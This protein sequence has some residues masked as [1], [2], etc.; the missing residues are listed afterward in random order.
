MWPL[1]SRAAAGSG[2]AALLGAA[3]AGC[4]GGA[5]PVPAARRYLTP[6]ELAGALYQAGVCREVARPA[7][8]GAGQWSCP[9]STGSLS[10]SVADASAAVDYQ[11][12][13]GCAVSGPDWLVFA[14]TGDLADDV[15]HAVGGTATCA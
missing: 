7:P 8:G 11:L 4:G 5:E 6:M 1:W 15:R 9:A 14:A 12:A 13:G 10:F 2:V 3:L